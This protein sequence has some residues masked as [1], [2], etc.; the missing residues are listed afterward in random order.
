MVNMISETPPKLDVWLCD[1]CLVYVPFPITIPKWTPRLKYIPD[2]MEIRHIAE[3]NTIDYYNLDFTDLVQ[4]VYTNTTPPEAF[5]S[6]KPVATAEFGGWTPYH[7]IVAFQTGNPV[8]VSGSADAA[9]NQQLGTSA[10]ICNDRGGVGLSK[11]LTHII[12]SMVV[13]SNVVTVTTSEAHGLTTE[14][15]I[16]IVG[17]ASPNV[18]VNT[19]AITSVADSTHFTF[20]KKV[21]NGTV[22]T[23][24]TITRLYTIVLPYTGSDTGYL[25]ISNMQFFLPD[26]NP[27]STPPNTPFI[28][29]KDYLRMKT[30]PSTHHI[31][32]G[33]NP[34]CM[35]CGEET[36]GIILQDNGTVGQGL[37]WDI[38]TLGNAPP[39]SSVIAIIDRY[40]RPQTISS[41]I[42]SAVVLSSVV[43][44]T[45]NSHGLTTANRITIQGSDTPSIDTYQT[46]ITAIV[47]AN[48]FKI[49]TGASDGTVATLSVWEVI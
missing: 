6:L 19:Q 46:P 3:D 15:F 24:G 13:S 40:T 28:T 25:D 2:I 22:S 18:D 48:T 36:Y 9:I 7:H 34:P 20:A 32:Q 43:T 47:D 27:A 11:D 12:S 49:A 41:R 26:L 38:H 42:T 17:S 45:C 21:S 14:D 5:I 31:T 8:N 44:V 1:K 4:Y 33:T 37:M 23:H 30:T 10:R 16:T 35:L 39:L 29:E